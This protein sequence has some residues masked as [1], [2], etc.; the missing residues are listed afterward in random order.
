M[1]YYSIT[2]QISL[3][4]RLQHAKFIDVQTETIIR[5][6]IAQEPVATPSNQRAATRDRFQNATNLRYEPPQR[7]RSQREGGL[8][9]HE[10]IMQSGPNTK[11][12]S[13]FFGII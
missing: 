5:N 6:Q 9:L 1:H 4:T 8:R 7:G 10:I 2:R 11:V 12:N 3:G 13:F